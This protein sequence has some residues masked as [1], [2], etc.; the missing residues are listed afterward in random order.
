[1]QHLAKWELIRLLVNKWLQNVTRNCFTSCK[2][3][4]TSDS[5][6]FFSFFKSFKWFFNLKLT[7]VGTLYIFLSNILSFISE[8]GVLAFSKTFNINLLQI[9][10]ISS[11]TVSTGKGTIG[12]TS[13]WNLFKKI[14]IFATIFSK[15]WNLT[16]ISQ[17][18]HL[19]NK[20]W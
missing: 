15:N 7:S 20:T 11:S 9:Y 13:V 19:L 12:P 18:L 2:N 6:T 5:L 3:K 16:V 17:S 10:L 14:L 4:L 1:M 8:V